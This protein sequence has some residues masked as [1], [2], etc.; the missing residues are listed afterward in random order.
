[1]VNQNKIA[2]SSEVPILNKY[3]NLKHE[4]LK[5]NAKKLKFCVS[6]KVGPHSDKP[7]W[8]PISWT[9]MTLEI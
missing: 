2:V 1:M 5:Y 4:V 8:V 9:L 7:T 6:V 3:E